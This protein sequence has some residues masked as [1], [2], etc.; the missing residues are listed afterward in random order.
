MSTLLPNRHTDYD[1]KQ[2]LG[3][4]MR[5]KR[6]GPICDLIASTYAE[7][8]RVTIL[9]IG[10]R[11]EYWKI[12][13]DGFLESHN[14]SV[15]LVN[16]PSEI[17]KKDT[18]IFTHKAGDA[19][20]LSEY[21]DNVFDIVHSNSVIEHVGNWVN[22]KAFARESNRLAPKHFIQTPYFWFPVEPHYI[23]PLFH[24]LPRPWQEQLLI[25]RRMGMRGNAKDR[26]Q[27]ISRIED[28]PRLLDITTYRLLFPDSTILKERF[29]LL[30]KS[31]IAYRA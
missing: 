6:S 9:D 10:G 13:P 8:G 19:C 31:M 25:G 30:V 29:F 14:V 28:T 18:E 7:K 1:S 16:L 4:K 5:K 20:D 12:M 21:S 26:D 24:W 23:A 2:S 3:Y 27:A 22:I 15:T 17:K 11:K